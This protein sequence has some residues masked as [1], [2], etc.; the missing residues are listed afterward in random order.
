MS[1]MQ[2]GWNLHVLPEDRAKKLMAKFKNWRRVLICWYAN[3]S[4]LATN[5][6][7][8]KLMIGFLDTLEEFG[9]LSLEEWN[10][11]QIMQDNLARL[12]EQQRV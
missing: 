10:F 11:R 1:V 4:N 6:K 5:I 12:L 2:H 9:D 7:N 8:N 3:I